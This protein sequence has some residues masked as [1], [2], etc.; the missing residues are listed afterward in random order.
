MSRDAYFNSPQ[1][2]NPHV[3]S[4]R[5]VPDDPPV[6]FVLGHRYR[7]HM[8]QKDGQGRVMVYLDRERCWADARARFGKK[9]A[10]Y[11][12]YGLDEIAWEAFRNEVKHVEVAG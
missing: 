7:R 1:D 6:R 10:D 12:V 2:G 8:S 9:I 4:I 11:D 5:I 3:R